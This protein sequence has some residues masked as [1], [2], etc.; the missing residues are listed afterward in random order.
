MGEDGKFDFEFMRCEIQQP[1]RAVGSQRRNSRVQRGG[2]PGDKN[3][4]IVS[5]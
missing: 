4:G 1:S 5:T 3:A 2:Q